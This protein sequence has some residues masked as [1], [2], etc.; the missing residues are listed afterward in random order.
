MLTSVLALDPRV[1]P[2]KVLLL[3]GLSL[4][5]LSKDTGNIH[6]AFDP[7]DDFSEAEI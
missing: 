5:E 1:C 7:C 3:L 2:D 6:S 4:C